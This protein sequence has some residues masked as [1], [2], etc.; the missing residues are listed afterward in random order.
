MV[1]ENGLVCTRGYVLVEE[2]KILLDMG[3][4]QCFIDK[5][6]SDSTKLN[7]EGKIR[8]ETTNGN[9]SSLG[10]V[11]EKI[12]LGETFY[13][14]EFIVMSDLTEDVII[15]RDFMIRHEMAIDFKNKLVT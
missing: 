13:L 5:S 7:I 3:A 10:V 15:G 4:S 12:Q 1:P 9:K 2:R 14:Q 6:I 8:V 11:L